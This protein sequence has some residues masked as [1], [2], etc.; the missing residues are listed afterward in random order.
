[1][2]GEL[3]TNPAHEPKAF[4]VMPFVS[5]SFQSLIGLGKMNLSLGDNVVDLGPGRGMALV[6]LQQN[7]TPVTF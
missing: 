3:V 7:P 4:S 5:H 2:V 6:T 1:M